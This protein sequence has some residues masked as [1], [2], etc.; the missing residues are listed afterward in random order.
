MAKN[1]YEWDSLTSRQR[2]LGMR[3]WRQR[4]QRDANPSQPQTPRADRNPLYDPTSTLAGSAL[5]NA[6]DDI[7]RGQFRPVEKALDRQARAA[8]VQNNALASRVAGYSGQVDQRADVATARQEAIAERLNQA[9]AT[10]GT[11]AQ[12]VADRVQSEEDARREADVAL[13]GASTGLADPVAEELAALRVRAAADAQAAGTQGAVEGANYSSLSNANRQALQIRGSEQQGDIANRLAAELAEIR[14]KRGELG[15]AKGAER[16][17]QLLGLRQAGFE[18]IVTT[19]GLGL[20]T[21]ELQ[22]DILEQRKQLA[23]AKRKQR[24]AEVDNAFDRDDKS[25]DNAREDAKFRSAE[26]RDAYQRE[27]KLGVYKPPTRPQGPGE[28][29][30]ARKLKAGVENAAVDFKDLL[31][32]PDKNGNPRSVAR[33]EEI[34]RRRGA[35]PLVILAAGDIAQWGYVKPAHLRSLRNVGVRVPKNWTRPKAGTDTTGGT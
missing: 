29:S 9:L 1:N 19:K 5:K 16:T 4:Q 20:K 10:V 31:D 6:I 27:N 13:Q 18:N 25:R 30:D 34:L 21:A 33:V 15:A 14:S 35:P 23:L 11:Q 3:R 24:Q 26:A 28:S 32:T 8:R 12:K 22:S 2:K 7:V 17:K